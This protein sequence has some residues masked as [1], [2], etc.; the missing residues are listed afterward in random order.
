MPAERK[1]LPSPD[2][3]H[4]FCDIEVRFRDLDAMGHVNNAVYFTYLEM[5]RTQYMR[6]LG[7]TRSGQSALSLDFPFILAEISC[8]YLA[9]AMLGQ[10]LR[11]HIRTTR[12]GGKSFEFE[13]LVTDR[14]TGQALAAGESAQVYYD[15]DAAEAR[16]VSEEFRAKVEQL[17]R[18]TF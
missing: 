18:R 6:A 12:I 10:N 9:A 2:E 17:E 1:P 3:F 7:Y 13:Y 5:A 14:E 15:Y 11:A 4:V 8:R 16:P